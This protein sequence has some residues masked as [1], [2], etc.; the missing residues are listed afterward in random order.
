MKQLLVLP[1]L[2]LVFVLNGQSFKGLWKGTITRDFGNETKTDSIQFELVQN[3]DQIEGYSTLLVSPGVIIRSKVSG[4]Y[5]A[6][7]K[8]L[9][10]TETGVDFNNLPNRGEDLFLDR[11]LLSYDENDKEILTGKSVACD[12]KSIYTR[13]RMM[14]R[15]AGAENNISAT[16]Y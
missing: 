14:I 15:K 4:S 10:L 16:S 1:L 12:R 7:T 13:S 6:S 2:A 9:R 11:Y 5:H 3:G 8:T